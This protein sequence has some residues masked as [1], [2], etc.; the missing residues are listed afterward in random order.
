VPLLIFDE[1]DANVGGRMGRQIGQRMAAIAKCHQVVCVTHLPQ[2][3]ACADHQLRVSKEVR[4]GQTFTAVEELTGDA[5]LREIA[6]MIGGK[7]TSRTTL[8]QAREMLQR[9][10]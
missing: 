3:A 4:K 2:I 5:R 8:Q 10:E 6:E 9:E 7:E 1:I